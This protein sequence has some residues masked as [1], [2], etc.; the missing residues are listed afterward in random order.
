MGI[1]FGVPTLVVHLVSFT[2]GRDV[3]SWIPMTWAEMYEYDGLNGV[4]GRVPDRE[5]PM[6][7]S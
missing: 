4:V 3:V 5:G 7:A 1:S 6:K 2:T